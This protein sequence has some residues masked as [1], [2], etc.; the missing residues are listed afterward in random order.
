VPLVFLARFHG[1]ATIAFVMFFAVLQVGGESAAVR[2]GV[3]TF[4]TLVLVALLLIFLALVEY[5]DHRRQ[6]RTKS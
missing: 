1:I 6:A 4:Y 2:L 5:L 3:P